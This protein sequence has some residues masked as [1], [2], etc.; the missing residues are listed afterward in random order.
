VIAIDLLV[1]VPVALPP[2]LALPGS[3]VNGVA[4]ALIEPGNTSAPTD[5]RTT[6]SEL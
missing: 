5:S 6:P 3:G 1:N 2:G 4:A